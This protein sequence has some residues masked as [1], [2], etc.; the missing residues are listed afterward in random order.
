[1]TK[2]Y[3]LQEYLLWF[4]PLLW[5]DWNNLILWWFGWNS[6]SCG[7]HRRVLFWLF[8]QAGRHC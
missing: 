7:L 5:F 1:M 6:C 8:S 2:H 3:R 4:L